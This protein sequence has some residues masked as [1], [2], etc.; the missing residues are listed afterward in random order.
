MSH[1]NYRVIRDGESL[2]IHEVHYDDSGAPEGMTEDPVGAST[3]TLEELK[4]DLESMAHALVEPVID[5][6][7]FKMAA[8]HDDEP[9]RAPT[10]AQIDARRRY[11]DKR[12]VTLTP[13]ERARLLAE[14]D[15]EQSAGAVPT[16]LQAML[17]KITD[18]VIDALSGTVHDALAERVST[19]LPLAV[20]ALRDT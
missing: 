2:A 9:A 19:L 15:D 11:L 4:V 13:E 6:G 3:E 18:D 12:G 7:V 14:I 16:D 20:R 5:V 8:P 17:L 10:K 1:W